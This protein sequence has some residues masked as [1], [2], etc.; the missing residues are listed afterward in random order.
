[1]KYCYDVLHSKGLYLKKLYSSDL[2][3]HC[4]R[5]ARHAILVGVAYNFDLQRLVDLGVG[6]LLHDFGKKDIENNILYKV[7]ALST[8]EWQLV[9]SHPSIGY[10][11]LKDYGFSKDVVKIIA[12][13]H[14]KLDGSGYPIGVDNLSI[15]TQIVTVCDMHDGIV[16]KRCYHDCRTECD[17]F[18]ILRE[19]DG[20]NQLVVSVLEDIVKQELGCCE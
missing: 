17:V 20:I 2:Y 7:G 1:M 8:S 10:R 16:S 4:N 6:S 9:Q 15:F 3:G 12:E 11:L 14:E 19:T 13:H 18:H 5:V